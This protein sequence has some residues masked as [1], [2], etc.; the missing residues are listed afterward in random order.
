MICFYS[1][2]NID[3][4]SE[5]R[6][7][8]KPNCAPWRKESFFSKLSQKKD[9]VEASS[10]EEVYPRTELEVEKYRNPSTETEGVDRSKELEV[11]KYRNPST[12][13][14]EVDRSKELEV[15]KYRNPSTETEEVHRSKELEVEKYRNP[16]T[17]SEEVDRSKELEVEKYRNPSTESEEVDRS[18]ELEVEKYR[19]PST[20]TEEVD[21]SKE[22]EVEKY[23]NPSTES[24]EVDR[25]KELEV[26]KYR[27]P[28]TE[29]EEVDRSKELE[30]EKYRNPSTETEE[31]DRSKEFEVEKY[32]NR[33]TEIEETALEGHQRSIGMPCK[34]C[35]ERIARR[36]MIH[37][38]R[39][40]HP[41]LP[42][43]CS[44]CFCGFMSSHDSSQHKQKCSSKMFRHR[45]FSRSRKAK[46]TKNSS[47]PL[48][49]PHCVE[50]FMSTSIGRSILVKHVKE[51]HRANFVC[52]WC[53][54][55]TDNLQVGKLHK[56]NASSFFQGL[57]RSTSSE[58][59]FRRNSP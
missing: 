25:S 28:S 47:E 2:K 9:K 32:R 56:C 30:V 29:T 44:V 18:K 13:S 21:R 15:E 58:N 23:G 57:S 39:S 26:E 11:E 38:V 49:C 33:G 40:K 43:V 46:I 36:Y 54:Y 51:Q 48:T 41:E 12:E 37:H 55:N 4:G 59:H 34:H 45:S 52:R 3:A 42:F 31:F 6:Y 5:L 53:F 14:E 8:Y 27:N 19:N 22:L 20:E 10:T 17:E 7:D 50:K 35:P 16:S 24:E 1:T